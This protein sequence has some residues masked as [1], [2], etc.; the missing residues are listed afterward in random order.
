MIRPLYYT[1]LY[2][3]IQYY[4]IQCM[5]STCGSWVYMYIIIIRVFD[6]V[7]KTLVK[8]FL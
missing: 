5:N 8:L 7:G 1:I 3:T 2:Y 6:V 4:T